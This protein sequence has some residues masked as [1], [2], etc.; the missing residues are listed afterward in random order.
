MPTPGPAP[1]AE[2]RIGARALDARALAAELSFLNPAAAREAVRSLLRAEF[3]ALEAERLGL[4]VDEAQVQSEL[5]TLEASLRAELGQDADLEAFA[6]ESAGCAWEEYRRVTAAHLRSNQLYQVCV[7]AEAMLQPRLR[8]HWLVAPDEVTARDWARQLRSGKDPR[9]LTPLSLLRGSEPD[10]SFAPM[11]ARLPPPH[12]DALSGAQA[13]EIVGP[14]Q[15]SGDRGWWVGRVAELLP[16]AAALPSASELLADLA[17][18]PL[19]ALEI[20]TWFEAMRA[21]YTATGEA[22][23]IAG[24]TPAFVPLR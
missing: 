23:G 5:E 2:I 13:G 21:R 20:R 11:P 3:A 24:L 22:P 16:P 15:F 10:D 9:A 14:F 4:A 17:R 6:Q 18:R 12:A 19:Q 8:L 1:L 7:R